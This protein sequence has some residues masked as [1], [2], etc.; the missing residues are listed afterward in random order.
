VAYF[1]KTE[2]ELKKSGAWNY[3]TNVPV[4]F[5]K[6]G[7]K[8]SMIGS[9]L[10]THL[11]P[12]CKS[13]KPFTYNKVKL[14]PKHL[15]QVNMK[16]RFIT[17]KELVTEFKYKIIYRVPIPAF[18][19]KHAFY[20]DGSNHKYFGAFCTEDVNKQIEKGNSIIVIDNYEWSNVFFKPIADG[21]LPMARNKTL[22]ELIRDGATITGPNLT[23]LDKTILID[24]YYKISGRCPAETHQD[25]QDKFY[26]LGETDWLTNRSIFDVVNKP[27]ETG[28]FVKVTSGPNA[29]KVIQVKK[30]NDLIYFN[31]EN[32]EYYSFAD[33]THVSDEE[34]ESILKTIQDEVN[35]VENTQGIHYVK[36]VDTFVKGNVVFT[37]SIIYPILDIYPETES[38]QEE[39]LISNGKDTLLISSLHPKFEDFYRYDIFE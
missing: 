35:L 29:G 22:Q 16:Y 14:S 39:Y 36:C 4:G 21:E 12:K 33:I 15:K 27:I 17:E 31:V 25:I 32:D 24:S 37:K 34:K 9:V 13:G 28:D 19:C 30:A 18:K 23:Y 10:P 11:I 20:N 5:P 6:D 26:K 7:S 3:S 2:D 8:N 1:I 38:N